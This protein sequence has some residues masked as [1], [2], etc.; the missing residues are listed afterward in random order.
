MK[1]NSLLSFILVFALSLSSFALV[2]ADE[3][4]LFFPDVDP[5]HPYEDGI[6][7]LR[8]Q[9]IVAGN[10]DGT[11]APDTAIDRAAFTKIVMEAIMDEVP[12]WTGDSCFP[13]VASDAWYSK[14]VCEAKNQGIIGG[15][16][17]GTFQ[18]ANNVNIAEAAKIVYEAFDTSITHTDVWYEGYMNEA[19]SSTDMPD[20][21]VES[22]SISRG[23][24]AYFIARVMDASIWEVEH[25]DAEYNM[26][27]DPTTSQYYDGGD[28]GGGDADPYAELYI[29]EV[30]YESPEV[31]SGDEYVKISN[32]GST[33]IQLAG[34]YLSGEGNTYT[35]PSYML[36]AGGTVYVFSDASEIWQDNELGWGS[37]DNIWDSED[38]MVSLYTPAGVEVDYESW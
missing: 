6:E 32:Y 1:K 16:P 18:P 4:P 27:G 13:D 22:N 12:E 5:Y 20:F 9:G 28:A 36:N 25:V 17:D 21:W 24:M 8:Q 15:Y 7:H 30:T 31:E 23:G 33:D 11:Y 38:G 3:I 34:F 35:F 29:S 37:S 19:A 2:S 14:Y 26:E 10:P